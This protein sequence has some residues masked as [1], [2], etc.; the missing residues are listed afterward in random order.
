MSNKHQVGVAA[1]SSATKPRVNSLHTLRRDRAW[2][3]FGQGLMGRRGKFVLKNSL[4][5][6]YGREEAIV[7]V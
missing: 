2:C 1:S 4:C 3:C 5:T 7:Y 6:G